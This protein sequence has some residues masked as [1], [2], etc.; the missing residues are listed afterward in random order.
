MPTADDLREWHRMLYANCNVPVA[1]YV[2]NFRGDSAYPELVDYEVGVG[3]LLT[4]GLPECVGVWASDVASELGLFFRN[5]QAAL[6]TLDQVVTS[7]TIPGTADVLGEVVGLS[8]AVHGEWIRIHPFVNGNG[9]TARFLVAGISLR[10]GLP[11]YLTL[12][13]RPFDVAYARASKRSMDRPP[14]F[15]GSHDEARSV[16]AHLLSLSLLSP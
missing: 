13:P 5:L 16:F 14:H 6:G 3:S 15:I 11:I 4:D 2:G 7:G 8:A 10:Y 12:K 1:C 9:R